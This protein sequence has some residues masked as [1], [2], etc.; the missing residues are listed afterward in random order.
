M[1]RPALEWACAALGGLLALGT[2][3]TVAL[4]IPGHG[5]DAPPELRVEVSGQAQSVAGH[6]IRI[7]VLNTGAATAAGVEVEGR[8]AEQ[9]RVVETSRIVFDYVPRGS[10]VRGGLWFQRDPAAHTLTVQ[11]IGYREP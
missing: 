3:G 5:D 7:T 11:P 2:L 8:L 9:G 4:Q 10:A 6:L 1:A